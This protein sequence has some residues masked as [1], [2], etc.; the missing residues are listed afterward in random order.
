LDCVAD[1]ILG[2]DWLL[3]HDLDFLCEDHWQVCLRAKRC[4]TSGRRV[5][6]DLALADPRSGRGPSGNQLEVRVCEDRNPAGGW[7]GHGHMWDANHD[8]DVSG[9]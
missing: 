6:V 5:R 1:M 4:C 3:A 7:P 8:G 2:Y 9:P